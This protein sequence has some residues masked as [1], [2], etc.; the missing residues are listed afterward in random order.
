MG[1]TAGL[2]GF[3]NEGAVTIPSQGNSMP[4][5]GRAFLNS[6]TFRRPVFELAIPS[7][8]RDPL[9]PWRDGSS[10]GAPLAPA[11]PYSQKSPPEV[12][13]TAGLSG[14]GVGAQSTPVPGDLIPQ[15]G[16]R[17]A[18]LHSK[19]FEVR[20]FLPPRQNFCHASGRIPEAI[21]ASSSSA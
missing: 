9:A 7:Q 17:S 3:G 13:L 19:T 11:R 10:F 18:T 16:E 5:G 12:Q 20:L 4:E 2:I 21:S 15:A 8:G 6:E 1:V 14:S